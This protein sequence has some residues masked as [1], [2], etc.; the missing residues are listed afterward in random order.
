MYVYIIYMIYIYELLGGNLMN[1]TNASIHI[2]GI[3][4]CICV[5]VYVYI[6]VYLCVCMY[7]CIYVYI[8]YM[9]YMY[10]IIGWK[11]NE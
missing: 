9:I 6:Y 7:V 4:I 8:I 3:Y 11:F 5:C 2:K 1:S 10:E